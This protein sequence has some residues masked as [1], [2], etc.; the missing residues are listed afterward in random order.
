MPRLDPLIYRNL[1]FSRGPSFTSFYWNIFRE[2]GGPLS[3]D[4]AFYR[5]HVKGL[6][7]PV[8]TDSSLMAE[9]ISKMTGLESLSLTER[10]SGENTL[11]LVLRTCSGTGFRK[12]MTR[13]REEGAEE[14]SP[15]V[16]LRRLSFSSFLLEDFVI[17]KAKQA[18]LT[19]P[20]FKDLTHIDI[21]HF[22]RFCNWEDLRHCQNLTHLCFNDMA[23]SLRHPPSRVWGTWIT[24][25]LKACPPSVKVVIFA[26]VDSYNC[27]FYE[28][29]GD[30]LELDAWMLVE[31]SEFMRGRSTSER[32]EHHFRYH[33]ISRLMAG[34]IDP[35]A[36]AGRP[37]NHCD[38]PADYLFS[39]SIVNTSRLNDTDQRT[40]M[41]DEPVQDRWLMAEQLIRQRE[42]I[43]RSHSSV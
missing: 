5:K 30:E 16:N 43:K 20:F 26:C 24:R 9:M 17:P 2:R 10:N 27:A 21:V 41:E 6:F 8:H 1:S 29:D 37:T 4:N 32:L 42:E 33:T 22:S 13:P 35:R 12:G 11:R 28:L 19:H 15:F 18:I 3:K 14:T 39:D 38:L 36:V 40:F 31:F 34:W 25:L 7:V 23:S